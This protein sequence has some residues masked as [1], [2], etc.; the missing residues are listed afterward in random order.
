M[1]IDPALAYVLLVIGLWVAATAAYIPGT[2]V[3][4]GLAVIA[5]LG[6]LLLLSALPTNLLGVLLLG[7]GVVGFAII[8]FIRRQPLWL[9]GIGLAMQIAGSLLL[10]NGII[11]SPIIMVVTLG[12]PLAYHAFILVP[13]MNRQFSRPAGAMERDAEIVGMTG[14][15]VQLLNPVGTVYVNSETWTAEGRRKL[16]VGMPV[17]VV[18]REGLRLIVDLDKEKYIQMKAMGEALDLD[19]ETP[20]T[21]ERST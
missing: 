10:Y 11:V 6:A 20:S 18:A 8:P 13:I 9:V 3:I 14:R 7:I 15:V 5:V 12:I 17:V 19:D 16:K 21:D 2:G 1:P 4:D